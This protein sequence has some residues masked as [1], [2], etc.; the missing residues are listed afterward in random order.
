MSTPPTI[1]LLRHTDDARLIPLSAPAATGL[2]LSA[3]AQA[4][5][6]QRAHLDNALRALRAA[7]FQIDGADGTAT[8]PP[9]A[10]PAA[11]SLPESLPAAARAAAVGSTAHPAPSFA[12]RKALIIVYSHSGN[13]E[14]LAYLIQKFI[15]AEV[16]E[17]RP[18]ML[19]PRDYK[20]A[21]DQVKLENQLGYLPK[22]SPLGVNPADYDLLFLGFPT[23]D[24]QIPP[25]VKN[26][27]KQTDL[28]GKTL[29]PFTSYGN[30]G[31]GQSLEQVGALKPEAHTLPGLALQ[32]GAD[33]DGTASSLR[34]RR[35]AEA[36]QQVLSWLQSIG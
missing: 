24:A 3:P 33:I 5:E 25:P 2:V 9:G 22:Y 17:L 11:A 32:G 20:A 29:A 18:L 30:E 26:W 13:T 15:D 27:L 21:S 1:T 16:V 12:G 35:A 28:Q 19:Y 34:G 7:G 31:P 14:A 8:E 4:D 36:E 6:A 23:W 10:A